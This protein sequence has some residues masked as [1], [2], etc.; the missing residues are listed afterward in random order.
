LGVAGVIAQLPFTFF[1]ARLDYELRWYIVTD[2]SLR[3]RHGVMRVR[4][5]TMTY[6]NI[7]QISIQQGPLQRLLGIEDLKV[8]TAGGGDDSSS[9]DTTHDADQES[10]HVGYFRGVE[11]AGQIR[12]L[13]QEYMRR[14]LDA[15]L[16]DPDDRSAGP[17]V[18]GARGAVLANP[19]ARGQAA[20]SEL[21]GELLAAARELRHEAELLRQAAVC[22]EARRPG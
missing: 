7:Q 6:A 11:N 4:E 9:E 8:R 19:A 10:M 22:Q 21:A 16:G 18:V 13:I 1:L 2:R 15:G 20:A 5:M 3:L 17:A 12:D 14:R